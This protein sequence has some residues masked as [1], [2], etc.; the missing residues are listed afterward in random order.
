MQSNMNQSS[1]RS[2]R[3]VFQKVISKKCW[4]KWW[5]RKPQSNP[6]QYSNIL[7][8]KEI[9]ALLWETWPTPPQPRVKVNIIKMRRVHS[10]CS[11]L[12]DMWYGLADSRLIQRWYKLC[13]HD[14][15]GFW[16][17][18]GLQFSQWPPLQADNWSFSHVPAFQVL[19]SFME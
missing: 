12:T 11:G 3:W 7:H 15:P 13:Y 8:R 10:L 2:L 16:Y 6:S 1:I 4:G 9:G 18:D 5:E 19:P 17:S 14:L